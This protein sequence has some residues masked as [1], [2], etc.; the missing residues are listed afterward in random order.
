MVVDFV[1]H[2]LLTDLVGTV[3]L[4]EIEGEPTSQHSGEYLRSITPNAL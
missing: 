2:P 4:I 3:K 1:L